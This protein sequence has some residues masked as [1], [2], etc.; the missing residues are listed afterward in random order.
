[1]ALIII[2]QLD[3]LM[4]SIDIGSRIT[5][6]AYKIKFCL[7]VSHHIRENNNLQQKCS[8]PQRQ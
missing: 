7:V 6:N 2:F 8:S 5:M 4:V 3:R 1:M